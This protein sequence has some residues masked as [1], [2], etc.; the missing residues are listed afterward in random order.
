MKE[1]VLI[2]SKKRILSEEDDR[3]TFGKWFE[4]IALILGFVPVIGEIADIALICYYLY[5]KEYIY[6][7]L[8]VIALIPTVGD[9]V[10]V[11]IIYTLR[12]LKGMKGA[13]KIALKSADDLAKIIPMDKMTKIKELASHPKVIQTATDL[14]KV[15]NPLI[16]RLGKKLSEVLKDLGGYGTAIGKNIMNPKISRPISTAIK[17]FSR[18]KSIAKW[19][20]KNGKD[21]SDLKGFYKFWHTRYAPFRDRRMWVRWFIKTNR[22]LEWANLPSVEDFI[23]NLTTS[24][25]FARKFSQHPLSVELVGNTLDDSE[26]DEY[27]GQND[28]QGGKSNFLMGLLGT[29]LG[30]FALKAIAQKV[31]D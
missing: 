25:D 10:A 8:T 12:G 19:M 27:M 5:R 29:G 14:M 20:A 3:S 30:I 15:K 13:S 16:S 2:L 4:N 7:A 23:Q 9:V 24:D 31:V 26:L 28:T 17:G 6:A 11:P 21:I 18:E 1:N 22:L